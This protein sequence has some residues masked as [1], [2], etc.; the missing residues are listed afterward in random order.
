MAET[1]SNSTPKPSALT[2][3]AIEQLE[4]AGLIPWLEIQGRLLSFVY[5]E[6]WHQ[7][8]G[9]WVLLREADESARTALRNECVR[10]GRISPRKPLPTPYGG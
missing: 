1:A 5:I 8:A 6:R 2:G 4:T 10:A 9:A 7:P 3:I